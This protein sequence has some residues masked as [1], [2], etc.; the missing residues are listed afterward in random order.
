[1][2]TSVTKKLVAYHLSRLKDKSAD[3]RLKS[4]QELSQLGDAEALPALEQLFKTDPD[5]NVRKAAQEAGIRIYTSTKSSPQ[6]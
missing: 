6:K 1:M 2:S 3:I 5:V 4:I